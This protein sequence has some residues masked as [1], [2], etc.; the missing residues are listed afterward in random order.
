M[1]ISRVLILYEPRLY[2]DLINE[3][4]EQLGLLDI[5]EITD[6][7]SDPGESNNQDNVDVVILPLD[8]DGIP[9]TSLLPSSINE[10]KLVAFSP[11]GTLG[12]RRMPGEEDWVEMRPFGLSQLIVEILRANP[13]Y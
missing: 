4:I 10:A 12:M 3:L 6:N 8:G 5:V 1:V 7:H 2:S 9:K 13:V 11:D